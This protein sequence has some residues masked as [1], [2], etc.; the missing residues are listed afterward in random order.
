MR[1]RLIHRRQRRVTRLRAGDRRLLERKQIERLS[2]AHE[3]ADVDGAVGDAKPFV[4]GIH[5]GAP[6]DAR[7]ERDQVSRP[8]D[9]R[10]ALGE[11]DEAKLWLFAQRAAAGALHA[12]EDLA[13]VAHRALDVHRRRRAVSLAP[14]ALAVS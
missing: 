13:E 5:R 9:H 6:E 2:L 3:L 1:R 11:A 8:H 7:E 10:R 4:V 14:R 12:A